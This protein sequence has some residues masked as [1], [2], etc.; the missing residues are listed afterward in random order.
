M[1]DDAPRAHELN[2]THTSK[3]VLMRNVRVTF[4]IMLQLAFHE[5]LVQRRRSFGFLPVRLLGC[6]LNLG[7][8][9]FGGFG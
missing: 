1:K 8:I 2:R 3:R 7:G 4:F 9:F 6:F 5:L